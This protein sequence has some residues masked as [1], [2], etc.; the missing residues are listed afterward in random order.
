MVRILGRLRAAKEVS[1][2]PPMARASSTVST[3][4]SSSSSHTPTA[5]AGPSTSSL[6][7]S[8]TRFPLPRLAAPAFPL[9]SA[10]ARSFSSS[11]SRAHGGIHRPKAGE[12]IKVTFRDSKGQDIKTVEANEGDDLLSVAHEYDIDLE[13]EWG[14]ELHAS[15]GVAEREER[16]MRGLVGDSCR[17]ACLRQDR[18]RGLQRVTYYTPASTRAG[19]LR[20][21]EAQ[22]ALVRPAVR[23][24]RQVKRSALGVGWGVS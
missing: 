5:A 19:R 14:L 3:S 20:C 10:R 21:S 1:L 9:H 16:Q 18:V 22:S 23:L 4:G 2:S 11:A 8:P 15:L 12:G 17:S 6:R 7:L 24:L 13:G